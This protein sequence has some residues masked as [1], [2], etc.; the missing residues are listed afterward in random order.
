MSTK[1]NRYCIRDF[2]FV[3]NSYHSLFLFSVKKVNF[4][5]NFKYMR[6]ESDWTKLLTRK[7]CYD[8]IIKFQKRIL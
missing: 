5:C 8:N 4:L 6:D 2:K 1:I 7:S 3:T